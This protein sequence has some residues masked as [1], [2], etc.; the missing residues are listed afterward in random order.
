[1]AGQAAGGNTAAGL[2]NNGLASRRSVGRANNNQPPHPPTPP[3]P[4]KKRSILRVQTGG[5]EKT[6]HGEP[7]VGGGDGGEDVETRGP[8]SVTPGWRGRQEE[9]QS[10]RGSGSTCAAGVVRADVPL[11]CNMLKQSGGD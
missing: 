11:S 3:H 2:K 10:S 4:P 6:G 7:G 5:R 1:M 9:V 8:M